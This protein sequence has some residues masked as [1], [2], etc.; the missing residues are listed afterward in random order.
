MKQKNKIASNTIMLLIFQISKILFPF[1]T[2]PYLTRVLTTTSYGCVSYVKTIMSYMQILVD[3]GFLLSATKEIIL[4]KDNHEKMQYVIGDT[5]IARV[6]L[7]IVGLVIAIILAFSLPLLKD[8]VLFTILS[9]IVV[10]ESI[11]LM[12]FLFRG[13]EKMH[14]ITIRFIIMK[15]IS[16]ILTFVFIKSDADI[17]LIPIFDIIS[18]LIA[19]LLILFEM[20]KMNLKCSFTNIKKTLNSIKISFIYF[21]SN[22]ASTSF[23]ALSTII[24]GIVLDA[25]NVA[26]WGICIQ[27]IGSIQACYNAISDGVYPEMIKTKNIN[28]IKK[29]FKIFIPLIIIGCIAAYFLAPWGFN[30]LGGAKYAPAVSTFRILVPTLLIGFMSIM[31]GWPTLGAIDKQK[32]VTIST[33]VSIAFNFAALLI[34]ILSNNFTVRMVAIIRVITEIV[35]FSLRYIFCLKNKNEFR[36]N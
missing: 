11:F 14:V 9:Y 25:T 15:V 6:I 3:F 27:I 22:I 29:T 18:S 34:L 36:R 28:I 21:L 8:N 12:D 4:S 2:L 7:G 1:V 24:I 17:L 30:L 33:I 16:T 35:L 23:N 10:F 31:L 13:L 26:Y 5:L 32:D 20:K 19:I